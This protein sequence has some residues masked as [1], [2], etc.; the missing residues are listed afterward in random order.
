MAPINANGLD[1]VYVGTG[2]VATPTIGGYQA[3]TP[4]GSDQWFAQETNP[5]TD[6]AALGRGGIDDGR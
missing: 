1:T 4:N 3:I 6:P 2:N 5:W